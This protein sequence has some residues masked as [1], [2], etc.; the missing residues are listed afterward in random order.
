MGK[1]IFGLDISDTSLEALELRSFLGKQKVRAKSRLELQTGI[2]QGGEIKNEEELQKAITKL[3]QS[4]TPSAIK[5]SQVVLSMPESRVISHLFDVPSTIKEAQLAETVHNEAEGFIPLPVDDLYTQWRVVTQGKDS[6][7]IQ[8]LAVS[9]KLLD[10]YLALFK[11][12]ALKP[13]II[14]SESTAL[15]AA[16]ALDAAKPRV[17]IDIGARVTQCLIYDHSGISHSASF[18]MGGDTMRERVEI[19]HP[20]IDQQTL[21]K[22]NQFGLDKGKQ[23]DKI[24]KVL[25]EEVENLGRAIQEELQ[26]FQNNNKI[27]I[28]QGAIVGG[29][30]NLPM[31]TEALSQKLGIKIEAE[32]SFKTLEMDEKNTAKKDHNLYAN[33]VGLAKIAVDLK[34]QKKVINLLP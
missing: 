13:I 30:A 19:E 27:K 3:L 1:R 33:V 29:A 11:K 18:A 16:L 31:I 25:V 4:A 32:D 5:A 26:F 12:C 9:R 6:Y 7:T 21:K 23:D 10:S 14:T 28:E 24:Y 17:V 34:L 2:V 15:A 20:K 8:Y 22:I